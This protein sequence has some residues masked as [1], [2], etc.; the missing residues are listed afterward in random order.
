[1]SILQADEL[2]YTPTNITRK[3][4]TSSCFSELLQKKETE[5][6]VELSVQ[7][8]PKRGTDQVAKIACRSLLGCST[9]P[10]GIISR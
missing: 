1:M 3:K 8:V 5:T 2:V 4:F 10:Y 7:F 9:L 6:V